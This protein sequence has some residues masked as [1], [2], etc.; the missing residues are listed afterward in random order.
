MKKLKIIFT[1]K[2]LRGKIFFVIAILLLI[3]V[4][5]AIPLPG[6]NKEALL[7]SLSSD[8]LLGFL[9]IFSGGGLSSLSIIMLGVGPYITASI[10]MQLLTILVPKFKA[11]YQE[12]GELGRKKFSQYSR[13]LTVPLALLQ[14]YAILTL[15][16]SQ[17]IIPALSFGNYVFN[18]IIITAGTMLLMWL[19]EQ[20]NEYGIGNGVSLIIFGG[21]VAALPTS[22][23]QTYAAFDV[24]QIPIILAILILI[25][26]VIY[27]IVLVTEAER[28]LTVTYSKQATSFYGASGLTHTY[29][30]LRLNQTGV[31]PI[32]FA[33]SILLFPQI[34]VQLLANSTNDFLRNMSA[35]VSSFL[36][37]QFY[38]GIIYFFLVV[39]FTYFYTAVTFDT[40][41]TAENLQK[42]GAFISGFRPGEATANHIGEV[43]SRIT[44]VGA[45][46]L[47][48]IAV[49]P[50]ILQA[51]TGINTLAVGG[52]S[53][54]IAVAVVI[55]LVK[56]V[57][58]QLTMHEY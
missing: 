37:N 43:L 32:I 22:V 27:G 41:K 13:I 58:A 28:P 4:L 21:I 50:I 36:S 44:L 2:V 38:Y 15:L 19:G 49:L 23:M 51:A 35:N 7:Q 46:F 45:L 39:L 55:D 47:G 29:I 26:L 42:S 48:V 14:G 52:T 18:V 54:L 9:N 10:I 16:I 8:S 33:I 5:A 20:I 53:L 34:L 31:M 1:D 24:S 17:K 3:R 6:V 57:E 25:I 11:M 30:P 56:K 40:D 12:E